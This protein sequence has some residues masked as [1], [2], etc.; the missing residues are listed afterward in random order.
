MSARPDDIPAAIPRGILEHCPAVKRCFS[1][2]YRLATGYPFE[3]QNPF[4]AA[5]MDAVAGYNYLANYLDYPTSNII[6]AGDSAGGHLVL[7]LARYLLT[8]NPEPSLVLPRA[9]LLMSPW[10]DMA[11][12]PCTDPQSSLKKF[13]SVDYV[14]PDLSVAD[15]QVRA[16][17]GPL[18]HSASSNEYLS[19]ASPLLTSSISFVGFPSTFILAGQ[20]ETLGDQIREL[21]DRIKK[22]VGEK[23]IT[24]LESPDGVHDFLNFEWF[25]P[26]RTEALKTISSWISGL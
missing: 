10:T 19:P 1:L 26:Q 9:L 8:Q 5:L 4:P 16:V 18:L 7:C 11:C 12:E 3:A 24:Y 6:C 22:D 13:A 20:V 23:E 14:D 21:K 17:A 25:E 15:Y 2:E